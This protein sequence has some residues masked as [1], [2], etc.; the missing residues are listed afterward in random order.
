MASGGYGFNSDGSSSMPSTG[1][2]FCGTEQPSSGGW[3]SVSG[4]PSS[5]TFPS[6]SFPTYA[7]FQGAGGHATTG[8]W[9][10]GPG[11]TEFLGSAIAGLG[12]SSYPTQL[13]TSA[14][15]PTTFAAEA[16]INKEPSLASSARSGGV[17][18]QA[19]S[20]LD[21]VEILQQRTH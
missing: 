13:N 11:F 18:C 2:R 1:Q 14:F 6:G 7:S 3:L 9:P 21:V 5:S 17:R 19:T 16:N 12:Q 15:F 20:A 4:P 8:M 10:G